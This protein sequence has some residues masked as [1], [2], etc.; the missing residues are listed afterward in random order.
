MSVCL[1]Q[2]GVLSNRITWDHANNAACIEW[3]KPKHPNFCI[4][5][6]F[7]IIRI[8]TVSSIGVVKKRHR[9][10]VL[11]TL[12]SDAH[13]HKLESP[14]SRSRRPRW[15]EELDKTQWVLHAR[16]V[17]PSGDSE[18]IGLP[19]L[20]TCIYSRKRNIFLLWLW[21]LADDL[22][23][24]VDLD[25]VRLN[26]HDKYLGQRLR[27]SNIIWTLIQTDTFNRLFYLD[28]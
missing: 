18:C 22:D 11:P 3:S 2:A 14:H 6:V 20:L 19:H 25:S 4:Y 15:H 17:L 13:F 8:S 1:L 16:S 27:S 9:S 24:K 28:H 26:Q 12:Y 5:V 21:T 10:P 23:Y 7:R